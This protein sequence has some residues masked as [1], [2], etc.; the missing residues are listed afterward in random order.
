MAENFTSPST[1]GRL[2]SQHFIS[3]S[4]RTTA[5]ILG[6][7]WVLVLCV[8]AGVS[9]FLFIDNY[10][11]DLFSAVVLPL[12]CTGIFILPGA[13]LLYQQWWAGVHGIAFY[14]LGLAIRTR[15]GITELQWRDIEAL[16]LEWGRSGNSRYSSA[17]NMT[18][19]FRAKSGETFRLRG[20]LDGFKGFEEAFYKP[21]SLAIAQNRID[22]LRAGRQVM[23]YGIGVDSSG[24]S[25]G[26]KS[27]RWSEM[28]ALRADK[29]QLMVKQNGQWKVWEVF[30]FK[31][32]Q[33]VLTLAKIFTV[34]E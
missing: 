20:N 7:I 18:Y 13:I 25:Y 26:K 17:T 9:V 3:K 8:D 1:L 27:V 19:A 34:V 16:W 5:T 30:A 21:A 32:P 24:L 6:V 14:D 15:R 10:Q 31:I 4:S 33:E 22:D 29:S 23:I 2:I 11:D 28:E 12:F